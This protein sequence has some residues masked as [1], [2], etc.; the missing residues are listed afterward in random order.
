MALVSSRGAYTTPTRGKVMN[1]R[2][3]QSKT[4]CNVSPPTK[5]PKP[6]PGTKDTLSTENACT[7]CSKGYM[8]NNWCYN[9]SF[10]GMAKKGIPA[11]DNCCSGK[12][13]F[14]NNAFCGVS[15]AGGTMYNFSYVKETG[16]NNLTYACKGN[17]GTGCNSLKDKLNKFITST[18]DKDYEQNKI[19]RSF[20]HVLGGP[21]NPPG[22][23]ATSSS[24]PCGICYQIQKNAGPDSTQEAPG[25]AVIFAIDGAAINNDGSVEMGLEDL[26]KAFGRDATSGRTKVK[27]R[28]VDCETLVPY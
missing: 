25:G 28:L 18:T 9:R 20:G 17:C 22:F 10:S 21:N 24:P 23:T 5:K 14:Q 26:A 13:P 3:F 11:A 19:V 4:T 6:C 7:T 27:Y 8:D 15:V 16:F 1:P 12:N 2:I